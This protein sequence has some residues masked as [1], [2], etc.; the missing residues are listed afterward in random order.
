MGIRQLKAAIIGSLLFAAASVYFC[1]ADDARAQTAPKEQ[2]RNAVLASVA[3][4]RSW[5]LVSKPSQGL[6]DGTLRITDSSIA[7]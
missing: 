1:E 3:E 4:Y 6:P 2:K 7:G 5:E